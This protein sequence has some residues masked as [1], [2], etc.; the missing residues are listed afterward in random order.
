MMALL[1]PVLEEHRSEGETLRQLPSETARAMTRAGVF[2][3]WVPKSLGG[4]EWDILSGV[5]LVEEIAKIDGSA[6]WVAGNSA[7]QAF[8]C[9]SLP[10]TAVEEIFATPDTVLAGGAFPPGAAVPMD[11]GYRV[12][13]QAPFG[14]G[15]HHATH[16]FTVHVVVEDGAPKLNPDGSP[17]VIMAIVPAAGGEIVD[18]WDT[19]GMRGTGSHDTRTSGTFVPE[20]YTT[21]LAP[22]D[23]P[24]R[25]FSATVFRTGLFA[26][27][28]ALGATAIGI[29]GAAIDDVTRLALAK[30]PAFAANGVADR[31][32]VQL[33]LARA[34]AKVDAARAYLH[35]AVRGAEERAAAGLWPSQESKIKLQL[36]TCFALEE[37]A[38]SVD[39]V[40]K[41]A[42]T[43]GFRAESR[44]SQY[45][46]DVHTISQHAFAS[47]ARYESTGKLLLG[48]P[49]DWDWFAL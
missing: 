35:E 11:G 37:A 34:T 36:A 9:Q 45:F 8:L 30:T 33:H 39:L 41:I 42:G 32:V 26:T 29:A 20:R 1:R 46:R 38:A 25:H 6:A 14:S 4:L 24:G 16:F 43:S 18:H 17:V 15:C 23:H 49:T 44:L 22:F 40:H 5:R 47:E 12:T 3:I 10:D 48:R 28:P 31:Q 27:L 19:F 21:L 13:G 2:R 7:G